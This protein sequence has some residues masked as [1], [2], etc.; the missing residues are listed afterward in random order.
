[1]YLFNNHNTVIYL[2]CAGYK[3][4]LE[5]KMIHNFFNKTIAVFLT[6][7]IIL[8]LFP[9]MG[10]A[11]PNPASQFGEI[12]GFN[13]SVFDHHFSRADREIN[14]DRWLAEA[15]LGLSQAI[16]AWEL[17][18]GNLY[19]NQLF[20]MEARTHV[21]KWSNEELEKRFSQWLAGRFFGASAEEAALN[22]SRMFGATQTD[23][24]WHFDA[25]DLVKN[26]SNH[27]EN[28][29]LHLYPELLA[30]IPA[31]SRI[32]MS[33]IIHEAASAANNAIKREFENIAAREERIFS[34]RRTRDILSLRQKSDNQAPLL[35]TERLITETQN[36]CNKGI[37][38][39]NIKIEQAAAGTGDLALLGE[40]WLNLYKEQFDRGLKAWEEAE[41]RFFIRRI[42]WEQETFRL[43]SEGEEVWQTAFI[44]LEEQ[45][46]NWEMQAK[47]LFR[48]GK[49]LFDN[50]LKEVNNNIVQAIQEFEFNMAIRIGE[51]T[52]RVQALVDM[53]LTSASAAMSAKE[54]IQFW[55]ERYNEEELKTIYPDILIEINKLNNMYFLYMDRAIEARDMILENYAGLLEQV[56]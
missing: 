13:R 8:G 24:T 25:E 37:E 29:I 11:Q 36:V 23:D 20:F 15:R 42:E 55:H 49:E 35:F 22:F 34:S 31:E 19:E 12:R 14:P 30:Y 53:Y 32:T 21:E 41:E 33:A 40:E 3:T 10:F 45:R 28:V 46:N 51:G 18:A 54:S 56:F 6:M 27:F 4:F 43:F 26:T 52:T 7:I 17:I 47:E 48:T 2:A 16:Y 38:E 44:R 9:P 1:M 50:L 39:I 5:K